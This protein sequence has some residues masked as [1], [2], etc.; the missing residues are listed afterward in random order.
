M[1]DRQTIQHTN[2]P[3]SSNSPYG[4]DTFLIPPPLPPPFRPHW[5]PENPLLCFTHPSS[6][7]FFLPSTRVNV[8]LIFQLF[9]V[10]FLHLASPP[11]YLSLYLLLYMLTST[12]RVSS[13]INSSLCAPF[14]SSLLSLNYSVLNSS[15]CVFHW[16]PCSF[17]QLPGLFP[18]LIT[19]YSL[20]N[21]PSIPS[22]NWS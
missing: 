7:L 17:L 6:F 20:I 16:T 12:S 9:N 13:P 14:N 3:K 10:L 5:R 4:V 11:L 1:T 21:S 19:L 18:Q 2:K 8:A 22:F 15:F